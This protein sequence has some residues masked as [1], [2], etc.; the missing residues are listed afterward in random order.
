MAAT[1]MPMPFTMTRNLAS[2]LSFNVQSMVTG[3]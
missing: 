2:T 1:N 3:V